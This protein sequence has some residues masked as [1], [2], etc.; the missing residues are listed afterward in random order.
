LIDPFDTGF[1]SV[2]CD[3]LRVKMKSRQ[4][5]HL[6]AGVA[7]ASFTELDDR[8]DIC[9]SLNQHSIQLIEQA[10]ANP[11]YAESGLK[12]IYERYLRIGYRLQVG[13]DLGPFN[14][15]P[16]WI[17]QPLKFEKGQDGGG[18]NVAVVRSP[19]MRTP[20]DFWVPLSAGFHYCKLMSPARVLEWIYLDGI[21]EAYRL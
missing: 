9:Q 8:N 21:R 15:G 20:Q 4:S 14:A 13:E 5:V 11:R 16:T 17:W 19:S 18:G 6:A 1:T 10:I 3:E 12:R 2:A 7:N